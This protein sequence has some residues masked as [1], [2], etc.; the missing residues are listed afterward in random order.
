MRKKII[1][2]AASAVAITMGLGLVACSPGDSIE[3]GE[4]RVY[5]PY[6]ESEVPLNAVAR[7]YEETHPGVSI[8]VETTPYDGYEEALQTQFIGKTAP[9]VLVLEPPAI[10]SFSQR[11]FLLDLTDD[12]KEGWA[13]SFLPTT[14][15]SL[16]GRDGKDYAA[17]WTIINLKQGYRADILDDLGLEPPTTWTEDIEVSQAAQEAGILP[18]W[19]GLAGN[20]AGLWWRL[21]L[22]LNAGFRTITDEVNIKGDPKQYDPTNPESISGEAYEADELYVAFKNGLIDPAKSP[23]YRDAMEIFE[24]LKGLTGDGM[25]WTIEDSNKTFMDGKMLFRDSQDSDTPGLYAS[26]EEAGIDGFEFGLVQFPP[27]TEAEWPALTAG[28]SNPLAAVRNGVAVNADAANTE[29]AIEF[30]KYFSSLE[31]QNALYAANTDADG[32]NLIGQVSATD[33]VT[34][35]AGSGLAPVEAVITPELSMYGFGM[36]PTFDKQDMDEFITQFRVNASMETG[37][38]CSNGLTVTGDTPQDKGEADMN[39]G[40]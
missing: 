14:L 3:S 1:R 40:N 38:V 15:G 37:A 21:T 5:S 7:A 11:G 23:L 25:A 13:E 36:P 31:G 22:T 27:V 39:T 24:R 2:V 10:T 26:A 19:Y 18:R 35:V 32:K 28:P 12:F 8:L 20:D 33:G 9:D 30:A 4:L 6:P 29:L 34:Y 16:R 17:P